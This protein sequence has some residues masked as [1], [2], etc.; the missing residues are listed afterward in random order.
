MDHPQELKSE[1]H[2]PGKLPQVELVVV[3]QAEDLVVAAMAATDIDH[4]MQLFRLQPEP[5]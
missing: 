3:E 2:C 4:R 5:A 1:H